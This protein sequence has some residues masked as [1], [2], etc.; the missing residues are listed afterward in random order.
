[1]SIL[2]EMFDEFEEEF[3]DVKSIK[4]CKRELKKLS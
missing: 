4:D 2:D 1:M 3:K